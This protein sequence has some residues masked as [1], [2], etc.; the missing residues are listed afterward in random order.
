MPQPYDYS[1]LVGGFQSPEQAFIGSINLAQQIEAQKIAQQKAAQQQQMAQ[2]IIQKPASQR[3]AQDYADLAMLMPKDQAETLMNSWN[4]LDKDNQRN[5]QQFIGQV[6]SAFRAGQPEIGVNLLQKR[7]DA[8]RNSGNE[9]RA[10]FWDVYAKLSKAHPDIVEANLGAIL[11]MTPGG[12]TIITS[13]E[14][15]SKGRREAELHPALVEKGQAEAEKAAVQAEMEPEKIRSEIDVKKGELEVA[16][17]NLEVARANAEIAAGRLNLDRDTLQTNTQLKLQELEQ[18]G[19][20]VEGASLDTMT[21][22]VVSAQA[23]EML[24][25]R[26]NRMADRF[27]AIPKR[28]GNILSNL[29]EMLKST[30]GYQNG[31]TQLRNEYDILIKSAAIKN[32]PPGAA[33]D[34][35]VAL[36]MKGFP[37]STADATYISS[38][39]RGMSKIQKAQAD[40]ETAQADWISENGNIGK[41]RRDI[42]VD[43]IRVPRGTSFTEFA[44]QRISV[45]NRQQAPERSYMRH[46]G[47]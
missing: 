30:F 5:T 8:E 33:S 9:Q 43:G 39:L 47:Q 20:K 24:A 22:A 38:F 16:K 12:D 14:N 6:Q 15:I 45:D 11:A 29:N 13:L 7:S 17:G 3:T 1:Q 25:D 10:G 4:A 18:S 26:T 31:L 28:T 34:K 23:N 2:A 21:K 19:S 35:D 41:A 32:L 42:V 37:P 36:A 27:A 44:R 46:A 40:A